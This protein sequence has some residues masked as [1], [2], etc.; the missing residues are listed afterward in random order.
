MNA[1]C[2]A[3]DYHGELRTTHAHFEVYVAGLEG[4]YYVRGGLDSRYREPEA[5]DAL[6]RALMACEELRPCHLSI[7]ERSAVA[8][9]F[10]AG[11]VQGQGKDVAECL[12]W[13]TPPEMWTTHYGAVEPGSTMEWNP[14]CPVHAA[15][16]CV[17]EP[18][19]A[20]FRARLNAYLSDGWP[21]WTEVRNSQG[22]GSA[23]SLLLL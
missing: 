22:R 6:V 16:R 17:V 23:A 1:D 9:A 13:H 12:C 19:D 20:D 10:L 18:M 4:R 3:W 7:R 21:G 2:W 5:R 15:G 11:W 14:S 8:A